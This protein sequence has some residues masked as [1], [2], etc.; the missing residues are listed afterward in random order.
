MLTSHEGPHGTDEVYYADLYPDILLPVTV[1]I[2]VKRL[3]VSSTGVWGL[4]RRP[5][6][7]RTWVRE[8]WVGKNQDAL[9]ARKRSSLSTAMALIRSRATYM[10]VPIVSIVVVEVFKLAR[11]VYTVGL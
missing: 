6:D 3:L 9:R 10:M 5:P 1:T 4:D 11:N 7:C 2:L 8:K